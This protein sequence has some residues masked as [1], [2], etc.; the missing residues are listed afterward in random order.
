MEFDTDFGIVLATSGYKISKR[1]NCSIDWGLAEVKESRVGNNEILELTSR[2]KSFGQF[3]PP[4]S[5]VDEMQE[6]ELGQQVMKVGRTT[7]VT[8]GYVS[9]I[10]SE[11]KLPGNP[12]TST[13]FAITG[14]KGTLFSDKGDS[15][16]FVLNEF[17]QLVGMIVGG[18]ILGETFV[19][20]I[21]EVTAD[22]MEMTGYSVHMLNA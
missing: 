14:L 16:A 3:F 5:T 12:T 19:T 17:G 1:S 18:G 2:P 20:P 11:C 13:E 8:Y 4:H 15:G 10:E 22:I 6:L 7:N 9:H 21:Q